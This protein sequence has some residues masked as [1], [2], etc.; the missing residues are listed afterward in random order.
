MCQRAEDGNREVASHVCYRNWTSSS[1]SMEAAIIAEGFE[2]SEEMYGIRYSKIFGD[3]DSSSYQTILETRPYHKTVE[4]IECRNH[5]LRNFCNKLRDLAKNTKLGS[6]SLPSTADAN[7]L[8]MRVGIIKAVE[9]H[10]K[11]DAITKS[12]HLKKRYIKYSKSCVW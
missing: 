6:K 12:I 2:K 5:L 3:G 11:E 1:S 9:Y 4:K 8:K 7:V 10:K